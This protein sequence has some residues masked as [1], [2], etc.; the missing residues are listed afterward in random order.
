MLS[1]I[2]D[3]LTQLEA[4]QGVTYRGGASIYGIL[5]R[6]D[7]LLYMGVNQAEVLTKEHIVLK[8]PDFID[9][10]SRKGFK[11]GN[12]RTRFQHISKA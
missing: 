1:L 9:V 8:I 3:R 5:D 11:S 10:N 7:R 12:P 6:M 4:Q 2:D